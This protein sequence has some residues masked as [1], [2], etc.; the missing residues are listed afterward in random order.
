[1]RR[2]TA[3]APAKIMAK[4]RRRRLPVLETNPTRFAA[5]D[6]GSC[7]SSV[8]VAISVDVAATSSVEVTDSSKVGRGFGAGVSVF[9][10]AGFAG[11]TGAG[12]E[13]EIA[14]EGVPVSVLLFPPSRAR[15]SAPALMA[16]VPFAI[17]V[18]RA[19]PKSF[20]PTDPPGKPAVFKSMPFTLS[21]ASYPA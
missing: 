5:R 2:A 19:V 3:A 9:G 11:A 10:A 15:D 14:T 12:A 1:M 17:A 4:T 20:L 21:I 16:P 8:D 13:I 18:K 6:E 7:A